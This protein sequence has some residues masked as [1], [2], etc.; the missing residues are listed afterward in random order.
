MTPLSQP[1]QTTSSGNMHALPTSICRLGSVCENYEG[2]DHAR[3]L[4]KSD[5]MRHL[6]ETAKILSGILLTG[7]TTPVPFAGK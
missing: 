7:M 2:K 5:Y 3:N 1:L 4:L 6:C